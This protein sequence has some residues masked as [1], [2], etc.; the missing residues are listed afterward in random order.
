LEP[1][2]VE[3]WGWVAKYRS[4]AYRSGNTKR[5]RLT[6][7]FDQAW[8]LFET[9]PERSLALLG[10]GVQL[11]KQLREPCWMLFYEYWQCEAY[12]FYLSDGPA[13][14]KLAVKLT[15]EV[16]KPQYEHCPI[17]ARIYR[18]LGDTYLHTDSIGF[19]DQIVKNLNYLENEVPL[20]RDTWQLIEC[21]RTHLAIDAGQYREALEHAQI[22]LSRA[23]G[24]DFRMMD[25]YGLLCRVTY[26]LG[27]MT[28][29]FEYA[30]LGEVHARRCT[31][32]YQISNFQVWQAVCHHASGGEDL[33]RTLVRA[34]IR[35]AA[36]LHQ[37]FCPE[38]LC[39]YYE[40]RGDLDRALE[41]RHIQLNEAVKEGN[42]FD[43]VYLRILCCQLMLRMD[44]PFEQDLTAAREA[45]QK[46]RK[47][48]RFLAMLNRLSERQLDD[49]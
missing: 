3:L 10:E 30:K 32:L 8:N 36:N 45:T 49:L 14:M 20:D 4:D 46:L 26:K 48:E 27:D 42:A 40:K 31:R 41:V 15:V 13:A 11:A 7:L 16:R 17:R 37:P 9:A 38:A 1:A 34:A 18:I 5:I 2:F 47:P 44:K 33:D 24:Y 19:A 28:T 43:E 23:Q 29:M 6:Q 21:K 39:V 25:A 12:L 35:R 22:Y